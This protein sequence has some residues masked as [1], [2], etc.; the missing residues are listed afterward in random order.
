MNLLSTGEPATLGSYKKIATLF[1]DKAVAFIQGQIDKAHNGEDAEVLAA[2]S[3][4]L[5]LLNSMR[6]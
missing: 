3:Q 1:G 6:D 2:E 4:M 5:L